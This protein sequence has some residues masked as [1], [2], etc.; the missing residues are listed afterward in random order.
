MDEIQKRI[1]QDRF[2]K[3]EAN[4]DYKMQRKLERNLMSDGR[5]A[6]LENDL[7]SWFRK[8][9][10]E[11]GNNMGIRNSILLYKSMR[12]GINE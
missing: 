1:L 10:V 7:F 9:L 8:K 11:D 3:Q 5:I 6:F 2:A 12:Y 4:E